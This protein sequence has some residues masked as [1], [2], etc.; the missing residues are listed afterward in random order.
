MNPGDI[1]KDNL[2]T[3]GEFEELDPELLDISS[4]NRLYLITKGE[5]KRS[6]KI[7]KVLEAIDFDEC[8]ILEICDIN[9]CTEEELEALDFKREKDVGYYRIYKN[10]YDIEMK[11]EVVIHI[12]DADE[13]YRKSKELLQINYIRSFDETVWARYS[14][15]T[16][17]M[18]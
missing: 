14:R 18:H 3:K 15:E 4:S 5:L 12:P 6:P 11:A 13:S 17:I 2:Y 8:K 7:L 16:M 1:V 10:D 9:N